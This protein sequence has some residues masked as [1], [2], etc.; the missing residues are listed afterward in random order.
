MSITIENVQLKESIYGD[1]DYSANVLSFVRERS[2]AVL[3]RDAFLI[4]EVAG[5]FHGDR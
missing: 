4:V 3:Q 2:I 1:K 5:I